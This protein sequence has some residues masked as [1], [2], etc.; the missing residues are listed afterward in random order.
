MAAGDVALRN[1]AFTITADGTG[2]Q[3]LSVPVV[4]AGSRIVA[5]SLR[6]CAPELSLAGVTLNTS[7]DGAATTLWCVKGKSGAV[8]PC[9]LAVSEI[10]TN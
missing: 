3:T 2:S 6:T 1:T 10:D 7:A 8:Y 5:I 4:V 9:T